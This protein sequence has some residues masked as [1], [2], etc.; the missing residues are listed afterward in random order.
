MHYNTSNSSC[1]VCL[2]IPTR[3]WKCGFHSFWWNKKLE[4][5]IGASLKIR[6]IFIMPSTRYIFQLVLKPLLFKKFSVFLI[7]FH[8]LDAR[9]FNSIRMLFQLA[10]WLRAWI[11]NCFSFIL[12]FFIV[13]I[14][15]FIYH[16]I[17]L[18]FYIFFLPFFFLSTNFITLFV[19][20]G[21]YLPR[22]HNTGIVAIS[23]KV[24]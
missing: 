13:S 17:F 12:T 6:K 19:L 16:W 23:Q 8:F 11:S 14:I 21:I 15:V 9:G 2:W 22:F 5:L 10:P 7:K 18:V 3:K 20:S 1:L 4:E 24:A